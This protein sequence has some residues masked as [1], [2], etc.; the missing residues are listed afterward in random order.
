MSASTKQ[1][2]VF[3]EAINTY[4][5]PT[6]TQS[7]VKVFKFKSHVLWSHESIYLN[8]FVKVK[9]PR[10]NNLH[11]VEAPNG[12]VYIVTMP[13]KFRKSVWTKRGDF[14]IVERIDEGDKVKA[15]IINILAK[16]QIRYIKTQGIW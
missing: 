1:K 16:D 6:E 7:I 14:L 4:P 5:L 10:G 12:D 15:E 13:V 11:E 3:L 8:I 9:G 2:H